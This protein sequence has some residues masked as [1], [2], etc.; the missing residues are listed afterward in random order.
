[1]QFYASGVFD[2][3]HCSSTRLTHSMLVTGYG[4]YKGKKYWLVKNR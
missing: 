2:T 1:M 3:V 4:T